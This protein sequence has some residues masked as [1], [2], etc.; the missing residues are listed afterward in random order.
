MC[1]LIHDVTVT[2]LEAAMR[3]K[4]VLMIKSQSNT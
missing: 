3:V 2:V 1:D 4:Q